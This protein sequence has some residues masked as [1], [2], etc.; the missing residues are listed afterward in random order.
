M[1]KNRTLSTIHLMII[2]VVVYFAI[3]SIPVLIF[4]KDK[5]KCELGL[6]VGAI[7]A[8]LM[9]IHMDFAINKSM[10][11]TSRQSLFLALSSVGRLLVTAGFLVLF[12][13]TDWVDVFMFIIGMLALKASA[14]MQPVLT[15]IFKT[16]NKQ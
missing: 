2:G 1:K 11:I 4:T 16:Q 13:L 15:R 3:I 9:V 7:A 10:H 6:L 5:F 8:V 12:I 14:Y